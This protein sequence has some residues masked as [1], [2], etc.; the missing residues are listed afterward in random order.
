GRSFKSWCTKLR[1]QGYVVE[2]RELRACDYGAPTSRKR[3]FVVARC[4]GQ[5]IVW[6]APTHGPG[7]LPFRTAADCIDW[8]LPIRSIFGRKKPLADKTLA[9]IFRGLVRFVFE[10]PQPFV[11]RYNGE[12]ETGGTNR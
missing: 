3:L 11:L 7:L 1:N 12:S 10:N 4:D 9:R 6:P 5:P 8:S 2:W